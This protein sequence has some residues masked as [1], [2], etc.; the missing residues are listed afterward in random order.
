[1]PILN[2]GLSGILASRQ[3]IDTTSQNI[4]NL[5]TKG[6]T[7][8]D[9]VLVSRAG[10]SGALSPGN[11]V[12]LSKLVRITDDYLETALWTSSAAD[13]YDT[14][15]RKLLG[16]IESIVG[17]PGT[18][19]AVGVDQLFE[20]M[21]QAA[22]SPESSTARQQIINEASSLAGRFNQMFNNLAIQER[23]INEQSDA[24]IESVNSM[25]SNVAALNKQI[26]DLKARGGNPGQLEDQR[27]LAIQDISKSLNVRVQRMEDGSVTLTGVS[28]QPVVLGSEAARL[29]LT[30]S[31]V[32]TTLNGVTFDLNA[33]GGELGA[34]QEYKYSFLADVKQSLNDQAAKVS[35]DINAQLN[36]GFD[37]NMNPGASLFTY[38]PSAPGE[39]IAITDI[40]PDELGFIGDDG[41]GSPVGGVGDNSNLLKV[42]AMRPTFYDEFTDLIGKIGIESRQAQL[43]AE[44]SSTFLAEAQ[45][46]RDAVSAVNQDEEAVNLMKFN[47]A[48]QANA[49]VIGTAGDLFDTILRMF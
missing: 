3:M 9:G 19:I 26:L 2:N 49:K 13:G 32:Q 34:L 14:Q 38:N 25:A 33:P 11:G 48:Y 17:S 21:S 36:M 28:G 27:N 46:R 4:A 44:A 29:S 45:Q 1:M 22:E 24:M 20:A 30:A 18:S 43:T 31:G 10:N 40:A 6:Y 42:I 7:R 16:Q 47:Q 39:T 12:E 23:Q 41:T 8:Q 35:D 15:Y 37:K 5:N